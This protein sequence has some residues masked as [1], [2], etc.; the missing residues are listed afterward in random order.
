MCVEGYEKRSYL[1]MNKVPGESG[2]Y[3]QDKKKIPAGL[4]RRKKPRVVARTLCRWPDG[5]PKKAKPRVSWFPA[6][7][8]IP[9][10]G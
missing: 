10:W 3:S 6:S 5:S 1:R 4:Q 7:A 9:S 8:G 2:N